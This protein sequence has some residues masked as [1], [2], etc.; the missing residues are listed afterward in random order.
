VGDVN[1]ESVPVNAHPAFFGAFPFKAKEKTEG[2]MREGR[3]EQWM[4]MSLL[5]LSEG[6]FKE[7]E[8]MEMEIL[9]TSVVAEQSK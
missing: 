4:C 5:G 1:E 3:E 6:P 2:S 8:E 7:K 9:E